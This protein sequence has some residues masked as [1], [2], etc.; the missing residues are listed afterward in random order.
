M[1]WPAALHFSIIFIF[2]LFLAGFQTSFWFQIFGAVTP[3]LMWLVVL[4]Y[5]ALYR[6]GVL[7]VFQV[8]IL[9]MMLAAFSVTGL[10]VFYGTLMFYFIFIYILKSRIFWSGAGYFLMICSIGS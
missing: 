3:P 4:T 8:L 9:T 5:I 7:A 1:T 6:E 10:K 2:S